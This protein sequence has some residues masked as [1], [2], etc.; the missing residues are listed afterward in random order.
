[1]TDCLTATV[2]VSTCVSVCVLVCVCV[3][4]VS[5]MCSGSSSTLAVS[6]MHRCAD[7]KT[8]G[9]AVVVVVVGVVLVRSSL[10]TR[11]VSSV[12]RN[13]DFGFDR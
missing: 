13:L 3:S 10:W 5:W 11:V 2:S 6:S 7:D 8:L 4:H 1:M 12:V 9:V